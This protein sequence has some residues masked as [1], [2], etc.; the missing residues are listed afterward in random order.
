M[1]GI[2]L[3]LDTLELE[4]AWLIRE[5]RSLEKHLVNL[6]ASRQKIANE[7]VADILPD[8]S[9]TTLKGLKRLVPAF[10]TPVIYNLFEKLI[11]A[12]GGSPAGT[13]KVS[14]KA[15]RAQLGTYLD[16][17]DDSNRPSSWVLAVGVLD[18]RIKDIHQNEFRRIAGGIQ[19]VVTRME[20][21]KKLVAT[22][23]DKLP[24]LLRAKMT[25][26]VGAVA[27]RKSEIRGKQ[28]LDF[29]TCKPTFPSREQATSNQG[30]AM[31]QNWL[32][33]QLLTDESEFSQAA[34]GI[35]DAA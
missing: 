23:P 2:K 19:D 3:L 13:S 35:A 14:L 29:S 27:A 12:V 4:E 22:D 16:N 31:I 15:L 26:A 8:I 6:V 21:L 20:A 9:K 32:W 10:P 1:K 30:I 11:R 25:R 17:T 24:P 7:Y 34:R 18:A 28:L 5:Q 33:Y